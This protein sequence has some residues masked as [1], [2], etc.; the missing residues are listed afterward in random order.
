MFPYLARGSR[1]LPA[2]E[3]RSG[4]SRIEELDGLEWLLPRRM[5]EKST[6][7]DIRHLLD[8]IFNYPDPSNCDESGTSWL[9][10]NPAGFHWRNRS[11]PIKPSHALS[12]TH[13]DVLARMAHVVARTGR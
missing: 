5:L 1:R 8:A 7:L 12:Y 10:S 6:R 4:V 13:A 2:F 3:V 9:R 11:N